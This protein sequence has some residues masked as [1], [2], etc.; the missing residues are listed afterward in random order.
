M[1]FFAADTLTGANYQSVRTTAQVSVAVINGLLNFWLIPNYGW[2]GA[3]WATVASEFLLTVF[4][5]GAIYRYSQ[6]SV[7]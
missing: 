3:I 4:L 6:T 1:H 7:D 2:H 5:W